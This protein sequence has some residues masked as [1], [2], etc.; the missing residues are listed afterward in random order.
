[1]VERLLTGRE[2]LMKMEAERD[3]VGRLLRRCV[4]QA[5]AEIEEGSG[6]RE[7]R[8]AFRA[9]QLA[10]EHTARSLSDAH[11]LR[12]ILS[13]L[14]TDEDV[15]RAARALYEHWVGEQV[16]E[17]APWEKL[18]GKDEWHDRARAALSAIGKA[19]PVDYCGWAH[20]D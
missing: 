4:E 3:N 14:P 2:A 9:A 19:E 20:A 10:A 15:E 8:V 11:R 5:Y 7:Y 17:C 13:A 6:D 18:A 12:T 16:C 1:M